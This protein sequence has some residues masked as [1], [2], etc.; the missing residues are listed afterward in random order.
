VGEIDLIVVYIIIII[1]VVRQ[2]GQSTLIGLGYPKPLLYFRSG[3]R[4]KRKKSRR[5]RDDL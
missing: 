4:K 3:K 2:L 1:N 5:R